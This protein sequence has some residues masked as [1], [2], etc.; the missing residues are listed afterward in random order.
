M[1]KIFSFQ[2]VAWMAASLVLCN[3][4][5]FGSTCMD[6]D[7]AEVSFD[8]SS[9][10]F[11][12]I[13]YVYVP[14]DDFI[15]LE[16]C[17]NSL[18][19]SINNL[20]AIDN[21]LYVHSRNFL[22][23]FGFDG[24]YLFDISEN[25]SVTEVENTISNVYERNGNLYID[26]GKGILCFSREGELL[27]F[28]SFNNVSRNEESQYPT[29]KGPNAS[30]DMFFDDVVLSD[31]KEYIPGVPGAYQVCDGSL[32]F[33]F[34]VSSAETCLCQYN[35][36]T[37]R[38]KLYHFSIN[39][40]NYIQRSFFKIIDGIAFIEFRNEEDNTQNPFLFKISLSDL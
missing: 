30:N 13:Q 16:T 11:D 33:T 19:P 28:R 6:I 35:L 31:N 22:H 2:R 4:A 10:N 24:E 14:D 38:S 32:Y 26:N 15:E 40:R 7:L 9:L 25:D 17:E 29:Q 12:S 39:N 23:V 3:A 27:S 21:C 18:V 20:F 36:S 5:S 34:Q 37:H 8:Q 1:K